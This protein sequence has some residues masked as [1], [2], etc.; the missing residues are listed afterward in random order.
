[1]VPPEEQDGTGRDVALSC[2]NPMAGGLGQLRA[3]ARQCLFDSSDMGAQ[4]ALY[5]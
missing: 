1:M 2:G 5:Q 4:C 3:K